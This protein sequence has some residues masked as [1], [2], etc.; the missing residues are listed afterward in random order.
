VGQAAITDAGIASTPMYVLNQDSAGEGFLPETVSRIGL[1][2]VAVEG[3]EIAMLYP[4]AAAAGAVQTARAPAAS[5][6]ARPVMRS[7]SGRF[8]LFS[9]LR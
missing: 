8:I 1:P 7:F 5:A 6:M 2:T 4:G 3:P 9:L